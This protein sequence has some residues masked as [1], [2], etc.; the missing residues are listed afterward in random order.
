MVDETVKHFLIFFSYS[1]RC[2]KRDVLK[3]REMIG[4][5]FCFAFFNIK[6][7]MNDCEIISAI[8]PVHVDYQL[9]IKIYEFGIFLVEVLLIF[10]SRNFCNVSNEITTVK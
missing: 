4:K 2:R 1:Q 8:H 6:M 9:V 3:N 7:P 5:S 10:I